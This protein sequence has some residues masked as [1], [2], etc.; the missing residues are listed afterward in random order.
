MKHLAVALENC[1]VNPLK[2]LTEKPILLNF[3]NLPT[4]FCPRLYIP[5][6]HQK[7]PLD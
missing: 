1:N 7:K 4:I 5:G 2:R 6:K 3:E